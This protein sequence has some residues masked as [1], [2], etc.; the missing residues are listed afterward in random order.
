MDTQEMSTQLKSILN[1]WQIKGIN[2][3]QSQVDHQAEALRKYRNAS[4]E[5][6]DK[7][8]HEDKADL[9]IDSDEEVAVYNRDNNQPYTLNDSYYA[10]DASE[11][12]PR[13]EEI[14]HTAFVATPNDN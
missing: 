5:F 4:R 14:Q 2:A 8:E 7:L 1:P 13:K 6:V 11:Q 9:D 10:S 12:E 3:L